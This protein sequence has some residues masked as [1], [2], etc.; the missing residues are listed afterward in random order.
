MAIYSGF[1][2][3]KWWF[4]VVTLVYQR[5][6][7]AVLILFAK[8]LRQKTIHRL[9]NPQQDLWCIDNDWQP[10]HQHHGCF[11]DLRHKSPGFKTAQVSWLSSQFLW[12]TGK[13]AF[14]GGWFM[15]PQK[16]T[17]WEQPKADMTI[18]SGRWSK[19]ALSMAVSI[20][21]NFIC[22]GSNLFLVCIE[23]HW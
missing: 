5:V 8:K 17:A 23:I 15:A 16:T 1:T 10:Y 7:V 3:K 11:F 6:L 9:M 13:P 14:V 20:D 18:H 21:T 4:S 19:M 2:H 22:L 12:T